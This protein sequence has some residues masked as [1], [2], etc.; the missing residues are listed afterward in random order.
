MKI[1]FLGDVVGRSGRDAVVAGVPKLKAEHGLDFVIVNGDNA[2]S[3]FGITPQICRDFYA[4]GVDVVTGGDHIWD[5]KEIVPFLANEKR[6]LRPHNLPST[7]PGT[8]VGI[9]RTAA[10]KE[11]MVVHVLGQVFHKENAACPFAAVRDAI[12]G[13]A[14]GASVGAIVV[15]FHAEA[16]SEKTAMGQYL[17]GKVSLVIGSHTHVPTSDARVLKGGT[18]YQTDAGMCGDYDSVIGFKPEAPI[19]R[20]LTKVPKARLEPASGD[21]SLCGAIVEIGARGLAEKITALAPS[22]G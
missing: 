20:F 12:A 11:V 1:L 5:Q 3:G 10:G 18:A 19:E 13:T 8:G 17:D 7:T 16:T 15:D 4:A 14:L 21:A 2:A 22:V 6:L 9:Y